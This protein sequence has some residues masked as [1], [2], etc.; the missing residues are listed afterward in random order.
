MTDA[1]KKRKKKKLP[2]IIS[3]KEAD[4]LLRAAD[5]GTV[6]GFRNRVMLEVMYRAGL[7]VS[8][9]T[10]LTLRDVDPDGIIHVYD[11]KGGDGT[12]YFDPDRLNPLIDR[13]LHLRDGWLGWSGMTSHG[14]TRL[15]LFI[16]PDGKPI[17]TRYIQRLVKRL[18]DETGITG[19][20]TPHVLRHTYATELLSEGFTLTEVQSALRHAHLQTTAVYLHV[21][22]EA[23]LR[24]MQR[25][26]QSDEG[27]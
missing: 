26:G 13:W 20:C 7:R 18:K 2:K 19:I 17:T 6:V 4:R 10:K 14:G 22:D 11:A 23:L 27:R 12:A 9:V 16:R 1:P 15:P 25:R 24:K 3:G 8:E 21:R 5:D